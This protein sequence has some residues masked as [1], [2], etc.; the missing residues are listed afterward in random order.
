MA[1][2]AADAFDASSPGAARPPAAEDPSPA[3]DEQAPADAP[4]AGA[5]AGGGRGGASVGRV[6]PGMLILAGGGAENPKNV[7]QRSW[8]GNLL[9]YHAHG[10][11]ARGAVRSQ[12]GICPPAAGRREGVAAAASRVGARKQN[13]NEGKRWWNACGSL[14]TQGA[15]GRTGRA[16]PSRQEGGGSPHRSYNPPH[17]GLTPELEGGSGRGAGAPRPHLPTGPV[18]EERPPPRDTDCGSEVS[19]SDTPPR[20]RR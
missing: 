19:P 12:K 1:A 15:E 5:D 10:P 6:P 17:H 3:G 4:G 11:K 16:E 18:H 20:R 2:A 8:K 13:L 7:L 14:R 9:R